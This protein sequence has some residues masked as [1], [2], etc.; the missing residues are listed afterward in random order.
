[1]EP[2]APV[3]LCLERSLEMVVG[4]LGILKA[5]GAYVPLDPGYPRERLELML[6]D[7]GVSVVVTDERSA[8]HLPDGLELVHLDRDGP[9]IAERP[10]FAP[11]QAVGGDDLAYIVYTSGSTGRPKG[12]TVPHRGVLRLVEGAN[13][14]RLAEDEV[15]LFLAPLSFDASTFEIWGC[16]LNGGRLAVLPGSLPALDA[17]PQ[18]LAR[19]GVTTVWLTAGLF[20]Q[21]VDEHLEDL[22]RLRQLLAGGDVLSPSHVRT[23]LATHP[24]LAL[25]D[26]YGPTE[27][28]TFACCH[29]MAAPEQPSGTIP[30]GRPI[31]NTRVHLLDD[32][33]EP[34]PIGVPGDLYI[35]GDGLARGYVGSPALS[36][37]RFLPDPFGVAPG[38]RLYRTGD[39]ARLLA[40]GR[41]AFLGRDDEQVKVRGFRVELREIERALGEHPEVQDAVLLARE[42]GRG[43]KQLVAYVV[44]VEGVGP[45]AQS[46]R[47][48]LKEKLPQ[49]MIPGAFVVL[50]AL[51]LTP[52]GKVDRAALPP[53]RG[54]EET[55]TFVAP[56]TP[57]EER[58][59]GFWREVLGTPL[60]GV[61]DDFFE[62]GG[63]SLIALR[64][65]S[66][67]RE[68]FEVELE[69]RDIFEHPT[70]A[71]LGEL[72]SERS[73]ARRAITT[74]PDLARAVRHHDAE[75]LL[76]ELEGLDD[77]AV[78]RLLD[79]M[80]TT[81][82][83]AR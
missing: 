59:A 11:R 71:G 41:I 3:G 37:E 24:R 14:A 17:L 1:M 63:Q 15:F 78:A 67:M 28:T 61:H 29:R 23:V 2:R 73:R 69:V 34:V 33:L 45:T 9:L 38:G 5:G 43:D 52:N 16:L 47:E 60:I 4:L 56:R 26:G 65:V 8:G 10:D 48:H 72:V 7:G 13:Y 54:A 64:L 31:S 12:V 53:P 75:R 42:D 35:G 51:P 74:E 80:L 62:L 32:H 46:L 27:S 58:L 81:E 83:A 57:L 44:A 55:A 30:I 39:R 50:D 40:D 6:G 68:G 20:H 77:E 21:M 49:H 19:N 70:V 66:R 25:V 76:A 79:H 82:D 18:A 22:G 36:A